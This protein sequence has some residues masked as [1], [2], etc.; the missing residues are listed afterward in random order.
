M[1]SAVHRHL[2]LN[3]GR[4]R[5]A[6]PHLLDRM[7]I[8]AKLNAS[9]GGEAER[10]SGMIPN[11]IG[12]RSEGCMPVAEKGVLGKAAGLAPPSAGETRS[13]NRAPNRRMDQHKPLIVIFR[14]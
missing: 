7:G 13:A 8:P 1:T 10:H 4:R 3:A 5:K 14:L 12:E 9:S 6:S 11:T 2:Q